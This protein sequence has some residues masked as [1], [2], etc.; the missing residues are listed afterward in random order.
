M[1][2]FSQHFQTFPQSSVSKS[3]APTSTLFQDQTYQISLFLILR[4]NLTVNEL[5]YAKKPPRLQ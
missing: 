1:N 4:R 3:H 2:N 5:T